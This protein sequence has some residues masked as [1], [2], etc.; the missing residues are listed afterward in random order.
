M[1][2]Q[3][4]IIILW[5]KT[6]LIEAAFANYEDIETI[7]KSHEKTMEWLFSVGVFN[8]E[9]HCPGCSQVMH[10]TKD[11][12]VCDGYF[13]RCYKCGL[14]RNIRHGTMY[15]KHSKIPIL[16]LTQI[17]FLYF[18]RG[19]AALLTYEQLTE[20]LQ[21]TYKISYLTIKA[22]FSELRA[23]IMKMY[24]TYVS[25][26]KLGEAGDATEI[27]ESL[28]SHISIKIGG[29]KKRKQVWAVG[30][31]ERRTEDV[32]VAVVPDRTKDTLNDLILNNVKIGSKIVTDD[33]GG[34]KD[35]KDLGYDHYVLNK[36]KEGYGRQVTVTSH[37]ESVWSQLKAYAGIYS[38]AIPSDQVQDFLC[39]FWFRRECR[40]NNISMAKE[41]AH[42]I[43]LTFSQ[44]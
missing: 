43:Q 25:A 5:K 27:D 21:G 26:S 34:Y 42:I 30:L 15:E 14:R 33:W 7:T 3:N 12:S 20:K 32:R 38:K 39:E 28:F 9:T 36:A 29:K 13:W 24:N 41:L 40:R 17:I 23:E 1:Q 19:T 37:I 2:A 35:L 22:I 6:K 4:N 10:R 31:F 44:P 8:K 16:V 18:C 11:T